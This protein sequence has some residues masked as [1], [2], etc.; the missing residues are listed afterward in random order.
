M[1]G[2]PFLFNFSPCIPAETRK[3][4]N[5]KISERKTPTART[6]GVLHRLKAEL[7]SYPDSGGAERS[8]AWAAEPDSRYC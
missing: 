5:V 6:V 7:T 1:D 4:Q 8:A 2:V 3:P